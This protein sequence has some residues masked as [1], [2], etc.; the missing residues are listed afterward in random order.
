MPL[1]YDSDVFS[2]QRPAGYD[3][4]QLHRRRVL[5]GGAG[6][7]AQPLG[8]AL[9]LSGV[10]DVV[11]VDQDRFEP[12]NRAKSSHYPHGMRDARPDE[13]PYKAEYVAES[14]AAMATAPGGTVRSANRW[15]QALGADAFAA[16]DVVISCVDAI[17]AR[18]YIARRALEHN[19][20]L[21]TGGFRANELWFEVYPAAGAPRARPCWNCGRVPDGDV[22]SCR[23]YAA[24]AARESVIPAIQTG[25]M[26]LAGFMAEAVIMALH[27]KEAVARGVSID[28]RTGETLVSRLLPD[29]HCAA[30]HRTLR[31]DEHVDVHPVSGCARDVV[32]ALGA[33]EGSV[34]LDTPF[35]RF[36]SCRTCE[37][38]TCVEQPLWAWAAAP[39]CSDC[40]GPW[41][42]S[43]AKGKRIPPVLAPQKLRSGDDDSTKPL[44]ALGVAPGELLEVSLPAR[45]LIVKLAGSAD[46]LLTCWPA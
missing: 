34:G 9:V 36:A 37:R 35:V 43:G 10:G 6:S 27:G 45:D 25:A 18:R 14:L 13:L 11:L 3:P 8:E 2:R 20:P 31:V 40:G 38:Q 5:I 4:D 12:H 7:L 16:A 29:P 33:S 42:R 23:H 24:L 1:P 39:R 19:T 41:P 26:T 28:L 21:V 44:A 32:A 30:H 17:P 22:F 46:E 15:V